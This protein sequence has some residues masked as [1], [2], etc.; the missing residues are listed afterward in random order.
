[1]SQ[2]TK[3]AAAHA[4]WVTGRPELNDLCPLQLILGQGR[5]A[6]GA[7][8]PTKYQA[9]MLAEP[10]NKRYARLLDS[11][12]MRDDE[13]SPVVDNDARGAL[14]SE[15]L[16]KALRRAFNLGQTYWQQA[17]SESYS[18]NKKAD[19]TAQTF[20]DLVADTVASFST[21]S[22]PAGDGLTR[23]LYEALK[24]FKDAGQGFNGWHSKYEDAIAKA[25]AALAQAEE[26]LR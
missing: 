16:E 24:A 11:Q 14:T 4:W 3:R 17:D 23:E 7:E 10:W 25:N 26:V 6:A 18:Q 21:P 20:S 15:S 5:L 1:M 9:E 13:M 19:T 22:L 8:E 12:S 2:Q